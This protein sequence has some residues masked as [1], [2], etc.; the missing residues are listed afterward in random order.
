MNKPTTM[1]PSAC[2]LFLLIA[3]GWTVAIGISLGL[4][5]TRPSTW[6]REAATIAWQL[7]AL[8]HARSSP[9]GISD[10]AESA[11][12]ATHLITGPPLRPREIP[13]TWEAAGRRLLAAV[14]PEVSAV[15]DLRGQ[16]PVRLIRRFRSNPD[17]VRCHPPQNAATAALSITISRAAYDQ[18]AR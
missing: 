13:D 7:E 12:P 10:A 18:D 4:I 14:A 3:A 2:A 9:A 8:H 6:R 5:G 16:R 11:A 17:C 15:E 1:D